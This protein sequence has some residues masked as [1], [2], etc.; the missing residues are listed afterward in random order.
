LRSKQVDRR[1]HH[2]DQN[3]H[4]RA[5][6]APAGLLDHVLHPWQQRDR[7]DADAGEGKSHR[8]A[9]PTIEPVGQ[10]QRLAGVTEADAAGADHDADRHIQMPWLRRQR[11]QQ[12]ARRHQRDAEFHHGARDRSDPSSGRSAG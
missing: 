5:G 11:R 10:I 3:A 4:R 9:A 8:E 12:Q 2:Q 6:G 1:Q 7:A